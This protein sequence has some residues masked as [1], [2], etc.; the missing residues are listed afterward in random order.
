VSIG[1]P[2]S[3]DKKSANELTNEVY[4]WTKRELSAF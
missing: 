2:I 1:K 4:E 3:S